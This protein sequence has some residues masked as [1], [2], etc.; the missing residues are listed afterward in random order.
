MQVLDGPTRVDA[1]LD[2]LLTNLE[3]LARDVMLNGSLGCSDHKQRWW[4]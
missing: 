4:N 2:L 1:Q 3:D